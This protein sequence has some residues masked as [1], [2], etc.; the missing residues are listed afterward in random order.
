MRRLGHAL[1]RRRGSFVKAVDG[2][3]RYF[4]IPN[5]D[6][7]GAIRLNLIGREPAGRVAPGTDFDTTCQMLAS[8]L[9]T[10][11]NADTGTPVVA[12]VLHASDHYPPSTVSALPDLF[13]EWERSEP[14]DAVEAPGLGRVASATSP[15]RS[16][17]HVPGGLLVVAGTGILPD[18]PIDALRMED[19]GPTIAAIL[20]VDLGDV[21]G[22][23]APA[24]AAPFSRAPAVES[25]GR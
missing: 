2:S 25:P 1:S 7:Y 8:R 3:R 19:I 17:D 4:A 21:D 12:R 10:W 16:G 22:H 20:G 6:A 24:V 15:A 23:A 14:I 9:A 13:V 18:A 5:N 11:V